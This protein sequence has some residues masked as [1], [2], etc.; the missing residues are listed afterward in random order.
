[1]S[2]KVTRHQLRRWLNLIYESELYCK[3]IASLKQY[4]D[5]RKNYYRSV[6]ELKDLLNDKKK[7]RINYVCS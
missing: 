4:N 5:Y 7:R 2:I 3:N 1:M 6:E